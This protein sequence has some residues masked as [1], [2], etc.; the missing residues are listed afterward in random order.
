MEVSFLET[1]EL[2]LKELL[3]A[4]YVQRY[5]IQTLCSE[6]LTYRYEQVVKDI[7]MQHSS[8]IEELKRAAPCPSPPPT[9]PGQGKVDK[10]MVAPMVRYT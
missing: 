4:F 2:K 8:S 3:S 9:M 5:N 6:R 10:E 1:V 7:H